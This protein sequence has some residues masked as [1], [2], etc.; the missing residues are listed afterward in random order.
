MANIVCENS[1]NVLNRSH[2][3]NMM[4]RKSEITNIRLVTSPM[5]STKRIIKRYSSRRART[6][7]KSYRIETTRT[8]LKSCR[9]ETVKLKEGT[10]ANNT[11]AS[12]RQING[13]V[14]RVFYI[15]GCSWSCFGELVGGAGPRRRN[16]WAKS[17][18]FHLKISRYL[19]RRVT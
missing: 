13:L 16:R 12:N 17:T 11:P 9:A 6:T 4:E 8:T 7:P 15:G 2:P 1:E 5:L 19:L 10:S 18:Q 3:V 14:S